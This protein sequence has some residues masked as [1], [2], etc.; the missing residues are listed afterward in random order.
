MVLEIVNAEGTDRN[1]ELETAL[2]RWMAFEKPEEIARRLEELTDDKIWQRFRLPFFN[3]W[4][5]TDYT[6]AMAAVEKEA[7]FRYSRVVVA[8]E[9]GDAAFVEY[10]R[11]TDEPLSGSATLN[12]ALF[13]LGQDRPDLIDAL[14]ASDLPEDD[15][16]EPV[17]AMVEGWAKKD[18]AAALKWCGSIQW[19]E[20]RKI[21][22]SSTVLEKWMAS[23]NTAA[24]EAAAAVKRLE[25]ETNPSGRDPL[26]AFT[27]PPAAASEIRNAIARDPFIG[28]AGLHQLLEASGV[29][30]D[31]RVFV[32]PAIDNDGWYPPDPAS[33]AEDAEKLPPGKTRDV[34]LETTAQ[35]WVHHDPAAARDFAGKHGIDSS[36]IRTISDQGSIAYAE[37]NPEQLSEI[38]TAGDTMD[39]DRKQILSKAADNWAKRDPVAATEWI[40]DQ[41]GSDEGLPEVLGSSILTSNI[42]GFHWART[43]ALGAAQWVVK[44]PEGKLRSD[45]WKAMA[46]Y[47]ATYSPDLS[48]DLSAKLYTDDNRLQVLTSGLEQIR[49]DVGQPAALAHLDNPDLTAEEKAALRQIILN[50]PK[51][52]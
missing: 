6:G 38:F 21:E 42:L 11:D 8:V 33:A 31:K 47:T 9:H 46:H 49:K 52:K 4:A 26:A 32:P 24:R 25:T 48:F 10:L 14:M 29:I 37:A 15:K 27:K 17:S 30:G 5:A 16:L 41:A 1:V 34:L 35:I 12:R 20:Q 36:Y 22:L 44:L 28:V 2:R 39:E 45:A 51:E 18:P 40:M 23:D 19:S 3:A 43:D 50:P 7:V 13:I